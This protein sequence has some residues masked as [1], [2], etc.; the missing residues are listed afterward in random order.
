MAVLLVST[1]A[2]GCSTSGSPREAGV[3]GDLP[4]DTA[5]ASTT[6]TQPVDSASAGMGTTVTPTSLG[7]SPLA[8]PPSPTVRS[9]E[10]RLRGE[11][12]GVDPAGRTFGLSGTSSPWSVVIVD[13]STEFRFG[14]G[15][16]ASFGDVEPEAT[17][18]VIGRT[19]PPNRLTA[20]RVVI[21]N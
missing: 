8:G 14:D 19:Q 18:V 10:V 7:G 13:G 2:F 15:G 1:A 4:R 17:V 11:V 20:R 3:P 6:V 21:L 5:V 12:T 9:E 16:P